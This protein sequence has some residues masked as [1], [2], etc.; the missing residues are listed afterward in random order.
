MPVLLPVAVTVVSKVTL[1]A[2]VAVIAVLMSV[3]EPG[4]AQPSSGRHRAVPGRR[5]PSRRDEDGGASGSELVSDRRR[6]RTRG[7]W[8]R[9]VGFGGT[10]AVQGAFPRIAGE[11]GGAAELGGG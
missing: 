2:S 5:R 9:L 10:R 7:W 1:R 8:G 6:W 3:L 11:R 4:V